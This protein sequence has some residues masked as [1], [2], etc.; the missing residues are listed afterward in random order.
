MVAFEIVVVVVC[1][2][3]AVIAAVTF[4]GAIRLYDKIGGLGTLGISHDDE[5]MAPTRE[6]VR[7]EVRQMVDA[8]S[9][10]RAGK[11][12]SPMPSDLPRARGGRRGRREARSR[13][14]RLISGGGA[15]A[16]EWG[17]RCH[18]GGALVCAPGA[19]RGHH[20][21]G[22]A[23]RSAAGRGRPRRSLRGRP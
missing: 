18:A 13:R 9:A 15:L 1:V 16:G 8:I 12:E 7:E 19:A 20:D 4:V 11:G 14:S 6:I 17:L 2:A 5:Q 23:T 21:R 10:L 3:S 22:C